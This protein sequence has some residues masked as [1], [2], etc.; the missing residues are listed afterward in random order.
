MSDMHSLKT[1]KNRTSYS[2]HGRGGG[3]GG[4][5]VL[6]LSDKNHDFIV[7]LKLCNA[8]PEIK[9]RVLSSQRRKIVIPLSGNFPN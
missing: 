6:P 2:C 5:G 3:G 8:C 7:L 4:G 1:C 9:C